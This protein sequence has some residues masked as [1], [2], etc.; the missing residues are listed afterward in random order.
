MLVDWNHSESLA[1]AFIGQLPWYWLTRRE[2]HQLGMQWLSGLVPTKMVTRKGHQ[3][4]IKH[5]WQKI[6]GWWAEALQMVGN[7]PRRTV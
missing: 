5:V 7:H 1:G 4:V 3:Q 6:Y 2:N